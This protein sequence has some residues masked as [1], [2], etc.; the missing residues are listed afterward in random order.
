MTAF[1]YQ[2]R[3]ALRATD[4]VWLEIY[5]D[6]QQRWMKMEPSPDKSINLLDEQGR[7]GGRPSRYVIGIAE[8]GYSDL[9]MEYQ[10][11]KSAVIERRKQEYLSESWIDEFLLEECRIFNLQCD[12]FDIDPVEPARKR[13]RADKE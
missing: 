13:R 5:C 8:N 10:Q 9:T 11:N 12:G 4:H 3:F 7:F 2:W 6:A 1:G